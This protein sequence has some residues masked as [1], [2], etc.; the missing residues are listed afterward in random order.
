MKM[1]QYINESVPER[2]IKHLSSMEV[3]DKVKLAI[4]LMKSV[5]SVRPYSMAFSGGK[6]SVL[7]EW[8]AK[9][10]GIRVPMVYNNTTIDPVGTISFCMKH[11]CTI[12]RSKESFLQLVEKKGMPTMFK[13]FCCQELKEKYIADYLFVGVRRSESLK[14]T[15]RY[16]C[17]EGSRVY[18]KNVATSMFYPLLFFTNED[19]EFCVNTHNI[20]MHPLYYD[21]EG[22]FCVDRRLGCIGCPLQSDRG[23]KDFLRYPKLLKQIIERTVIYHQNHG[24]TRHDAYLNVVYNLFYSNHG[25]RKYEQAYMGLFDVDPKET[26][27]EYFLF[28][29]P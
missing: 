2:S 8:L 10:A 23:K 4:S 9:E 3:Q 25:Y 24:R 27:E 22:R 14:R 29:L 7:M 6:D 12:V 28:D 20:E 1:V 13:R 11:N 19:V 21:H 17:F 26:L 18:S 15:N 16:T 5:H